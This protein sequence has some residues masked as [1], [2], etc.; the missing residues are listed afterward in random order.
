M[1]R[2][3]APPKRLQNEQ[4]AA[5]AKAVAKPR[6]VRR[7]PKAIVLIPTIVGEMLPQLE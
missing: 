4:V 1:K 5:A 7:K 2:T 6:T 3:R